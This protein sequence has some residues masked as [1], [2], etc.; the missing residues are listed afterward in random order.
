MSSLTQLA[1]PSICHSDLMLPTP[2]KL[3]SA[4]GWV[5]EL[6]YDGFRC[7]V[8]KCGDVVRLESRNGRDIGD[9]FPELLDEIRPIRNDF[10]SDGELVILDNIGCPQWDRLQ[11]R[12]LLRHTH[13]IRQAALEDPAVIFAFDL[14]WLNGAD[15]RLRTLAERKDALHRTL[16][17]NRRIRYTRHLPDHSADVWKVAVQLNLEGIVAKDGSSPYTAGASIHWQKIETEI[18]TARARERRRKARV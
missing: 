10:V 11:K 12:T 16:P 3:F 14:L 9:L 5:F 6:K 8:T 4:K 13:R 7:L 17:A 2:G 1:P 18:G 15:F